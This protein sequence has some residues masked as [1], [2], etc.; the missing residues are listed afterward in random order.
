MRQPAFYV[1]FHWNRAGLSHIEQTL[2]TDSLSLNGFLTMLRDGDSA[3]LLRTV[4]CRG[5]ADP[6]L[7]FGLS[8]TLFEKVERLEREE[9]MR[10][11]YAIQLAE[12]IGK[13]LVPKSSLSR[14]DR[15]FLLTVRRRLHRG[16]LIARSLA[17]AC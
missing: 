11:A 14:E 1:I 9:G 10:H 13:Q 2:L 6:V 7:A 8:P 17:S 3:R 12:Q 16:V 5:F 15:G 4:A